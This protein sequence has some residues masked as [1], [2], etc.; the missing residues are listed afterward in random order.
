M[1]ESLR[2]DTRYAVRT[3]RR[4]PGFTA[5][6]VLA[7]AFGIGA[8][9][10]V[11][12]VVNGVLLRPLPYRDPHEL[13]NIWTD[14]GR[15]RE[16]FP[17]VSALDA[18]DFPH[19][20][21][22]FADFAIGA[23]GDWTGTFGILGGDGG[24]NAERVTVSGVSA[25]FFSLLGVRPMLGRHF[26]DD[27]TRF[28]ALPNQPN[29]GPNVVI[30]S[31]RLWAR[32]FGADSTLIGRTIQLDAR[33]HEVVG[34]MPEGF[35][36]YLPAEAYF[37]NDAEVWKPLRVDYVNPRP[38]SDVAYTLLARLKPGITI[39]Q[40]TAEMD[41]V[42]TRF[43]SEFAD[44]AKNE[45][46]FRVVPLRDDV[47][48]GVRPI[49]LMLG[50]A[51]TLLLLIAC[52]NVANLLL[53]RA[54]GRERELAIRVA[55]G[56][57]RQRIVR[58][59]VTESALLAATGGTLGVLLA[60]SAVF[61]IVRAQPA[62]L[63]RL[64]DIGVDWTVVAVAALVCVGSA[65]AFGLAPA[66]HSARGARAESLRTG[67]RGGD[68]RR[69]TRARN[70]LIVGEIALSL[71]LMVGA[72]LL[73][74]SLTA[75]HRV[76]PGFDASNAVTFRVS[77]PFARYRTP[78]ERLAVAQRIEDAVRGIPGVI[79]TGAVSQLPLT[80]S[81]HFGTVTVPGRPADGDA[82]VSMD[83]RNVTAD[84]F[85]AMGT[86]LVE[87]RS[88]TAA[89]DSSQPVVAVID[90]SL[91]RRLWPNESAVG[92][93]FTYSVGYVVP[94]VEIVGVVEHMRIR[95]LASDGWPQV[96]VSYY[97]NPWPFLSYV[98]RTSGNTERLANAI[99][100]AATFA[101]G[102]EVAIH[103]MRPLSAIV[104]DAAAPVRFSLIV[105]QTIAIV[106]LVLAAVGLYGVVSYTVAQRTREFGVRLALG[107]TPRGLGRWVVA[108]GLLLVITSIGLGLGAAA[109]GTRLLT[110]LL[111]DVTPLDPLTFMAVVVT[112][113][114]V[115][116][117]ACYI[118][119][120]RAASISPMEALRSES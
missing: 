116:V 118:P 21:T 26:S 95:S 110:P 31:H 8:T 14:A 12:S 2:H 87:G 39:A 104:A 22:R 85:R 86:R 105:L 50:G 43:R 83:L 19:Y 44:H 45:T 109:A 24:A 56:A 88:L 66:I 29:S 57:S 63:P 41:A 11:I 34:V 3:L 92:K 119:A 15:G 18:R 74:R 55:L 35:R 75:L 73:V 51:T 40:A 49:L 59:L 76:R 10:T 77:I 82:G 28:V 72:G 67:G 98:V 62:N 108:Q 117:F 120:R 13:V 70:A 99:T 96:Y 100:S 115:A 20:T 60:W 90:V 42:G 6:A 89:D 94:N 78:G 54:S 46:Q 103:A 65:L 93:R 37:I 33:P 53:A 102:P 101:A 58:Q 52:A 23:G 114:V 80:G 4:R 112:L 16:V 79:S 71:V 27:E 69:R 17:A 68:T 7:I 47:V 36:L 30:L 38:R 5:I 107:E 64:G 61:L 48:K 81:G 32:R 91:A 84:Y 1:L 113:I 25:N 97:R 106:A 111:H 9:T